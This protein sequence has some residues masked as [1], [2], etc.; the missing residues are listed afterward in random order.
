MTR[1]GA[2]T[3]GLV[4]ELPLVPAAMRGALSFTPLVELA[5]ARTAKR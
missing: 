4:I 1:D 2:H 3:G 5:F